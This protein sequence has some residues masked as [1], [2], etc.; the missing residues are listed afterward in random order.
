MT[1]TNK[2]CILASQFSYIKAK[3]FIVIVATCTFLCHWTAFGCGGGVF[4]KEIQ[5]FGDYAKL[6]EI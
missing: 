5:L 6:N 2:I 1:Q 3:S 4:M